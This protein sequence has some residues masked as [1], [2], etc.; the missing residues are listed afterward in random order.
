MAVN[1]H[2]SLGFRLEK[3]QIDAGV[4]FGL[5]AFAAGLGLLAILDRIGLPDSLLRLFVVILTLAS[6][7]VAAALRRSTRTVYF[8]AA[9]RILPTT[10]SGLAAAALAAGLFLCLLPTT[11]EDMRLPLLVAAFGLGLL[12][13]FFTT[14][15]LLR[16]N[17]SVSLADLIATR[18]PQLSI[19][20]IAAIIVAVCSGLIA[21]AGYD[22]A[23]RG[24]I[25]ATGMGRGTAAIVLGA[26][27]CFL[28]MAGGL[29]TVLWVAIAAAIVLLLGLTLPLALDFAKAK[30]LVL[31]S[32]S[33]L[34][35]WDTAGKHLVSTASIRYGSHVSAPLL[36]VTLA[37]GLATLAPVLGPVI[38][39][40]RES[41]FAR[42]GI[43]AFIWLGLIGL[44]AGATVLA[45]TLALDKSVV[46]HTPADLPRA[47]Y[48]ANANGRI[49]LCGGTAT[50][51][52]AL[53]KD[54]AGKSGYKGNLRPEDIRVLPDFLLENLA[55]LQQ[56]G[57]V[58]GGLADSFQ[59]ALGLTLAAA[60]FQ[61]V[62]TSLGYDA[63]T[64]KRRRLVSASLRLALTRWLA[65]LSI[66]AIGAL[67]TVRAVD[68]SAA[69]ILALLISAAF[70]VPI[71]V[72]SQWSRANS[73]D[74]TVTFF[75]TMLLVAGFIFVHGPFAAPKD[76]APLAFLS[77][78]GGLSAG[79][80]S[81]LR[82]NA[83][84]E[85]RA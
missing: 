77:G 66:A 46:G 56:L 20:F 16:R 12:C 74:A 42:T 44:L 23:L 59:V 43:V 68:T 3:S 53:A 28:I 8:Y 35:L 33:D 2:E 6:F 11:V 52:A 57:A 49:T 25:S 31:P 9:G 82:K 70:L 34:A 65:I 80:L 71:L 19:R 26:S 32:I 73:L 40:R 54:C 36:V 79:L 85:D 18:F 38:A 24:F 10:Y 41:G 14:G 22:L 84:L 1:D 7:I 72:L 27:L 30:S 75:V 60:G 83:A 50:D 55:R 37:A 64:P 61:S 62:V 48:A 45:S 51:L 47:I 63:I 21:W 5:A 13:A 29:A 4:A 76:L 67:L 78:L 58:L 81:S 17:A 15:Y 69:V 39:S